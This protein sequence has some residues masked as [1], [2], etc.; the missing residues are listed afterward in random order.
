MFFA[1]LPEVLARRWYLV[2]LGF[3]VSG[4][5]AG[6]TFQSVAPTYQSR[7]EILLLPPTTSVPKGGNPYLVLGGLDAIGGVLSTALTDQATTADLK[8]KG[9]SGDFRVGLD[10]TSPAPLVEVQSES[11]TAKGSLTTLSMVVD[12]IPST[13][14]E[15][16][17]SADVNP[18]S[19]ITTTQITTTE[20]PDVL[21]KSQLSAVGIVTVGCLAL[22]LLLTAALD[23]L[24]IRRRVRRTAAAAD[25]TPDV[26]ATPPRQ[27]PAKKKPS[28][29]TRDEPG[30]GSDPAHPRV[31]GDTGRARP[32]RKPL[33]TE[34][35]ET[36][37]TS[38]EDAEF[39]GAQR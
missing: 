17:K 22:T 4:V 19:F 29:A 36:S 14:V 18:G 6:L 23:G 2:L 9:A 31:V 8:E 37:P 7:A 1:E 20:K 28:T 11:Q 34:R 26:S 16:Q 13:M 3:L 25:G 30:S 24:I 12:L 39:S 21:R 5:L 27:P 35:T 10:Q 32:D 38:D 15:I 33:T